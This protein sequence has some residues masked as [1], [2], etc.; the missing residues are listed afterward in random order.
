MVRVT[1]IAMAALAAFV[2]P[3]GA[4]TFSAEQGDVKATIEYSKAATTRL[5][6]VR[7]N[8]TLYDEV[9][10]LQAC[11]GDPCAPSGFRGDPPLRVLDLDGGG[12]PEVIY[13]AYTG[14][15]H[16]CSVAQIYRLNDTVTGYTAV[17]L[18]FGD[19]G[20]DVRDIGGDARPEFIS[21]DDA[22]AYRFTAYA[23][24]GLPILIQRYSRPGF[25]D[26][27]SAFPALVRKDARLW[28]K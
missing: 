15:A 21:R 4:T 7:N 9:P 16:C 14:G 18:N 12:E 27:T 25:E 10:A 6:I 2:A 3:A 19:P 11:G 1:V 8:T 26:V 13:S 17:A 5:T 20:F 23:F 28:R 22:F 24:S